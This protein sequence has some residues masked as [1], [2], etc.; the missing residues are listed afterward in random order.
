M[1]KQ[2]P[3]AFCFCITLFAVM[4][5]NRNIGGKKCSS[6]ILNERKYFFQFFCIA[7]EM[8]EKNSANA[9]GF[10]SM[11]HVKIFIAPFFETLVVINII[12]VACCL[13]SIM[14][15]YCVSLYQIIWRKIHSSSK[16]CCAC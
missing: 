12:F 5:N 6:H 3:L 15:M 1:T 2:L 9:A 16:P 10:V 8:I 13:N 11:F 7:R 14:K 4:F